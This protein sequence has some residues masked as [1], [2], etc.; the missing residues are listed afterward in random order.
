MN[1]AEEEYFITAKYI[2]DLANR[3]QELFESS[4]VDEKRQL[5]KLVLSNLRVEG[6]NIVYEALK[7][8]DLLL[9]CHDD[10]GWRAL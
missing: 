4:E 1:K 8:F 2:L 3:V 10:I 6:E 5:M 7:P 9:K